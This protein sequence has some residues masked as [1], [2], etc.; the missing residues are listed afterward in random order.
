MSPVSWEPKVLVEQ[1]P[2]LAG[3]SESHITNAK[4]SSIRAEILMELAVL[5]IWDYVRSLA[6]TIRFW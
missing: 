1:G 5:K 4:S 3:V 6:V 2:E